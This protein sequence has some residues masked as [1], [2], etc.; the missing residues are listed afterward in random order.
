MS[1]AVLRYSAR[2]VAE[3]QLGDL[4]YTSVLTLLTYGVDLRTQV[5]RPHDMV[6]RDILVRRKTHKSVQYVLYIFMLGYAK[7]IGTYW[8]ELGATYLL[9]SN[10]LRT[11]YPPDLLLIS[12]VF[13]LNLPGNFSKA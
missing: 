6:L 5:A 13:F 12:D 11:T 9:C 2:F 3:Y 7:T 8:T 1:G 4:Y 10:F